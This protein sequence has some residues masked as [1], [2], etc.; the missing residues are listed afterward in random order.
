[1]KAH[2]SA[3]SSAILCALVL[4]CLLQA[5]CP[6]SLHP[7]PEPHRQIWW[8]EQQ[9]REAC[10]TNLMCIDA[11]K[12]QWAILNGKQDGDEVIETEVDSYVK[13]LPAQCP[14]GGSYTYGKVGELPTCSVPG[15][16]LQAPT[17]K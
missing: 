4:S 14:S 7:V 16:A 17:Q 12:E 1:M 11:A 8:K 9:E 10:I 5:G 2:K 15:H 3:R 13:N 6:G